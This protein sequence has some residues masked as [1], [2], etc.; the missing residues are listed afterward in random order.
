M[1]FFVI[2]QTR[3]MKRIN[4]IDWGKAIAV[5]TVVFCHIPQ[6]QE[7]FY[8]RYV[9]S[10]IITIFFFISGYLKNDRDDAAEQWSKYWRS[11]VKPYVICN[12]LVYPYWFVKFSMQQGSVPTVQEA[13]KPIVE[14]LLLQPLDEPL[15]YL[16]AIL[17]MHL[18]IDATR[19]SRYFHVIMT[20][21]C[22]LSFFL[23][24]G[25]KYWYFAPELVPMGLFRRLPYYYI[26]YLMGRQMLFRDV[27]MPRD[28]LRCVCCLAASLLLF[29]W[30]LAEDHFLLH[31]ALFYP[32]N[33]LFLFGVL[34]GCKLLDAHVPRFVFR[35]SVGTL[36]V[37]GFH[38]VLIT[39]ANFGIAHL[40]HMDKICYH[41]YE[42]L[43]LSLLIVAMLYPLIA[44]ADKHFPSLLGL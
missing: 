37:I 17:I 11:L 41:W 2:L 36:M 3:A 14:S 20:A 28:A 5:T 10:C 18:L 39:C 44:L 42:A 9:Q 29:Y 38:M 1:N 7:W 23:Y 43:P 30:H 22:I 25:N 12:L 27:S 32:V 16:P 4:W 34:S 26:G 21:M 19:R 31:I 33:F 35:L 8:F 13:V 15:W 6:S 24:A 40:L